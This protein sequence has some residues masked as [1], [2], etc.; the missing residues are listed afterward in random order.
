[1]IVRNIYTNLP[2]NPQEEVF[3]DILINKKMKLE[4]IISTGQATPPGEWYD[5]EQ[6]EWVILLKGKA[7]LKIEGQ[8]ELTILGPGD[9]ILLPAHKKHRVEWTSEDEETIWLALH[10]T[11]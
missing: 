9:Y 11:V 1:M 4:R 2:R 6:D 5:Q 10:Y 8:S 3:E 7:G